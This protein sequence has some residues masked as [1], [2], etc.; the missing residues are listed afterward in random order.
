MEPPI[1]LPVLHDVV[2]RCLPDVGPEKELVNSC[3]V[4]VQ[5]SN[6]LRLL[7]TRRLIHRKN[8]PDDALPEL[9]IASVGGKLHSPAYFYEL[10]LISMENRGEID[11]F[12]HDDH[13]IDVTVNT[14]VG[15]FCME[16][17]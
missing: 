11:F 14:F 12:F 4:D 17:F 2:N 16:I 6:E 9:L 13:S 1:F 3:R 8:M 5:F 10:C 15:G 7:F